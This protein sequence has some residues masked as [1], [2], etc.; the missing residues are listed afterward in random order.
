MPGREVWV[1]VYLG[2]QNNCIK[3]LVRLVFP[4]YLSISYD[5]DTS[6]QDHMLISFLNYLKLLYYLSSL[7][8]A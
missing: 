7:L 6:E 1:L 5:Y 8:V 3:L 4:D 2:S